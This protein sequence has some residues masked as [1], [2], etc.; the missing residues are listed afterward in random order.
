L[1]RKD[2]RGVE[3][4]PG[5]CVLIKFSTVAKQMQKFKRGKS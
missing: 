3:F 2:A 1:D 4:Y 5:D